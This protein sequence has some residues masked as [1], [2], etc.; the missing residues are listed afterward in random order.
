[1]I[2]ELLLASMDTAMDTKDS[3]IRLTE[4]KESRINFTA[5]CKLDIIVDFLLL[6]FSPLYQSDSIFF[7]FDQFNPYSATTELQLANS[8][9]MRC[10]LV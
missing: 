10:D 7:V 6:P 2:N 9:D 4:S 8:G 5:G 1:M 3:I